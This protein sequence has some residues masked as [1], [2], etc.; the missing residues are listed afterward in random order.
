M[1]NQSTVAMHLSGYKMAAQVHIKEDTVISEK[2][3]KDVEANFIGIGKGMSRFLR[4]GGAYP[5][6]DRMVKAMITKNT[7]FPAMSLFGKDHKE[8]KEE[9]KKTKGPKR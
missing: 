1:P 9:E 6:D 5:K 8:I 7:T 2:Q 3:R 4:V